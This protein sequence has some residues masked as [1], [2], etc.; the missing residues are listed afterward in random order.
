MVEFRVPEMGSFSWQLPVLDILNTPP[1]GESEGD[2]YLV[3]TAGTGDFSGHDNE[4]AWY[5]GAAYQFDAPAAGWRVYVTDEDNFYKYDGS[6]WDASIADI[7]DLDDVPDGSIY[8][9]VKQ[10]ELH[11]G[12]VTRLEVL[13]DITDVNTGTKTFTVA[14]DQTD[15]IGA[16]DS[17]T[18]Q[19]S[20]GN[21]G[22]Y[23]VV[24]STYVPSTKD[25]DIVVTEVVPSAVADGT[26]A[27]ATTPLKLTGEQA[28]EAYDR[29]GQYNAALKAVVF[30]IPNGS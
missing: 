15:E 11:E 27:N 9:R 14:G 18:V 16:A 10:T 22:T 19:G 23:T 6:A 2:R 5:D 4:I 3:G 20:T 28:K 21:D 7:N 29:R 8:G 24:S 26:I 17:I 30:D 1:G 12:E 25:T 13:F